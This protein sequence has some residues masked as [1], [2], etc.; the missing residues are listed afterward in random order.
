MQFKFIE[1][2]S[3]EYDAERSLR[4]EVLDKP[5]GRPPDGEAS[6]EEQHSLHLIALEGRRI[7][8]CV[9]FHPES[10][11]SGRILEMAVSEKYQG[12][13]F[14]RQL[15]HHLERMLLERGIN[16]VYLYS[17]PDAEEFYTLM[18]YQAGEPIE[19]MGQKQRIMK[20][21]LK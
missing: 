14:G 9:C 13:G 15:L 16:D 6:S 17:P 20:K 19:K 7:V 8:G 18:G 3:P 5:M 1:P 12:R 11:T 4:W 21:L 2:N 10:A